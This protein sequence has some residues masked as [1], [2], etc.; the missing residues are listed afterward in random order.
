MKMLSWHYAARLMAKRRYYFIVKKIACHCV[1]G[2]GLAYPNAVTIVKSCV[3][4]S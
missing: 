1:R 4:S 3:D 2:R